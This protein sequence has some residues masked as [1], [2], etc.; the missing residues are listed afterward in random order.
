M[1]REVCCQHPYRWRIE[2]RV[3]QQAPVFAKTDPPPL[4]NDQLLCLQMNPFE[5]TLIWIKTGRTSRVPGIP[6]PGARRPQQGA[7]QY[8]I[9]WG[10]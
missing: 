5:G 10:E 3:K 2:H 7:L 1:L 8:G 9:V 4:G 6:A